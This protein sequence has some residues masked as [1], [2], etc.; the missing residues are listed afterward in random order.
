MRDDLWNKLNQLVEIPGVSGHEVD[1]ARF[2]RDSVKDLAD[3]VFVDAVGNVFAR[4]KGNGNG[5]KLLIAAH[6]D[7][8]GAVVR[9]IND[10]GFLR[11]ER[12]GGML[13][14]LMVGRKVRVGGVPGVIGVKSGH[15]QTPEERKQVPSTEELYVDVGA[16]SREEVEELGIGI[17]TSIVYDDGLTLF[18]DGNRFVGPAVDNRAGC[19]V[20]WQL[21]QELQD[22]N[23]AGE[24]W[25]VFTVQEEVGL[26]GAQVAAERVGPDIAIALDTIPC[27]GTPDVSK[28]QLHTGIGKGP[29]LAFVSGRG[30]TFAAHPK[31]RELLTGCAEENHI[32]YQPMI[33]SGGNNDASSMQLAGE[34][35]AAGSVTL[36][37]RYSHTPVEMGDLRDMVASTR[38]LTEVVKNMGKY[39]NFCFI[40]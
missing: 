13:D 6:A 7:Q 8:I 15:Y 4:K 35:I 1:V 40:G 20:L 18:S 12:I 31:V 36:P 2:L 21:L 19:A 27:G 25:A 3:E 37:R 29:V 14:S 9:Y 5:P 22:G 28:D 17:G 30:G 11:L 38:L 32:P 10:D 23:F 16:D 33:F 26:R 24:L 34:G 39:D